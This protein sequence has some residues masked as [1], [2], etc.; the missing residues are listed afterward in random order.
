[1]DFRLNHEQQLLRE[2]VSEFC[3]RVIEPKWIEIDDKGEIDRE[4]IERMADIGLFGMTISS[5]YGGQDGSFL[6][7]AIAAEQLAYHGPALSI[8]VMY[9]L[10]CSWPYMLQRYGFEE[11]KQELLPKVAAGDAAVGIA[12]TEAHGGSDV[13][14]IRVNAVKKDGR[15]WTISGEKSMVSLPTIIEK[16]PWGGGWFL[17]ART[18]DPALKHRSITDFLFLMKRGGVLTPGVRYKPWTEF[19]RRGLDTSVVNFENAE[20]DDI[21][22]IGEV[23]NGF[24]IAM[25]GFNLARTMIGAVCVGCAEWLMERAIEWVRTRKV[26]GKPISA[27]QGVSFKLAE[28]ASSLEAAKLLS[29]KAAWTADRYYRDGAGSLGEVAKLGAMAKLRC[30]S[31]AVD[32]GEEVMKIYGGASYY[33]ET[34]IFRAWLAAFSYV[35]GA[36][37]AENILRLI[38]A[39][40]VIGREFVE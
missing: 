14:S 40:E 28:F 2:Q 13:A 10:Q 9:L 22:R 16:M 8:A 36:E 29:Y 25:E 5:E 34:P 26:F 39:R 3:K 32:I 31:L 4:V 30:A 35:V 38:V 23:N 15:T 21:Y 27:Y 6:E 24:K 18:G 19:A 20:V 33:K 37:G 17:I 7:A 11:A 1:M 12:S